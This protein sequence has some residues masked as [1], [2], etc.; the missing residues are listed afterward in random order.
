[1]SPEQEKYQ[2][3]REHYLRRRT[4]LDREGRSAAKVLQSGEEE[5]SVEKVG[6]FAKKVG[7]VE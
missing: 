5:K 2:L 6:V 1:M 3:R 4:V 7:D